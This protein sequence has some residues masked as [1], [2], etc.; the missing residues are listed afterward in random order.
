LRL[1]SAESN[2]IQSLVFLM[3]R[4]EHRAAT[5][6]ARDPRTRRSKTRHQM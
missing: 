4:L 1:R 6:A 2:R 3:E 5:F